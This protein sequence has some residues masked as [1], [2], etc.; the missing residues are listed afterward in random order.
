[1]ILVM[2]SFSTHNM[3]E[4]AYNVTPIMYNIVLPLPSK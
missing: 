3:R 1:M 2:E 4:R